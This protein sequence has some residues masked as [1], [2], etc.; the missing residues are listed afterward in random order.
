MSF[1]FTEHPI[2]KE[3]IIV[4]N[5]QYKDHR[6]FFCETFREDEFAQHGISGFVQEN[7][8]RSRSPCFRG[9]HY[10]LKPMEQG[11]LVFCA[12][13]MVSDYILDIRQGSPTYGTVVSVE[14][15]SN[16][17]GFKAVWIPPGFAHGFYAWGEK[18]ANIIYK[19]TN[20]YSPS[21]E[22]CIRVTDPALNIK[23]SP[24]A[25]ISDKDANAP[26]LKDAENNFFY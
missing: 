8:S 7:F 23:I 5:A 14:L 20:F 12:C 6:G 25:N 10:Q 21:D 16:E 3:V 24:R 2:L 19:V 4:T 13:G 26:L 11:K 15:N 9:M 1:V 17:D 18:Y 22:R